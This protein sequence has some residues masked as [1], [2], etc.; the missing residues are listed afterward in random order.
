ME[1]NDCPPDIVAVSPLAGRDVWVKYETGVEGV[2]DL[3][4]LVE[5]DPIWSRVRTDDDFFR[6]VSIDA[7]GTLCWPDGADIA[8]EH[9]WESI[10]APRMPNKYGK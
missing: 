10:T 3:A 2:I 6:Q 4:P 7:L 1:H 5:T 8:P 9:I